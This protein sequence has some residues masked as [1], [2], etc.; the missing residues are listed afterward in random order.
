MKKILA[1]EFMTLDGVLERPDIWSMPYFSDEVG[2]IISANIEQCDAILMGRVTYQEWV[3]YWPGK[4]AEDDPFAGFINTVPKY[5]VSTTLESVEWEGATLLDGSN[6]REEITRLKEQDGK[7]IAV[8]G[9]ITVV[10]SLLREGLL[11]RLDLL[12]SPVVF[13]RGKRLFEDP[14]ASVGLQLVESRA[15]ANGVL[16]LSYALA[17]S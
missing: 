3:G 2:E 4:T 17:A 12:V 15:L 16:S 10:Q 7:D 8:S 1:G 6:F 5:V 9:S 11:D 14:E 13:G